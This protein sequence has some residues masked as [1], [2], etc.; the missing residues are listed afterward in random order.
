MKSV[1]K[2]EKIE[3]LIIAVLLMILVDEAFAIRDVTVQRRQQQAAA[4]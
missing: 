1:T 2:K 4:V 3:Y